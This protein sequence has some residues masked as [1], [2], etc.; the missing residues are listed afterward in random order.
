M[1]GKKRNDKKNDYFASLN[2]EK[3]AMNYPKEMNE[4]ER[5]S[6]NNLTK[7]MNSSMGQNIQNMY[8]SI[9][10]NQNWIL[11]KQNEDMIRLL[12]QLNNK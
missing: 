9:L 11:I 2:L 12:E 8:S 10:I 4:I 5:L 7:V 6:G 1:F 3:V